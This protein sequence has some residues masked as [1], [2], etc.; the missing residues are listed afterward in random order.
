MI[1]PEDE[2]ENP[3]VLE[4]EYGTEG[5]KKRVQ[6]VRDGTPCYKY[7]RACHSSLVSEALSARIS[8]CIHVLVHVD[9][10]FVFSFFHRF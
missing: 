7:Q 3:C 8:D 1:I 2:S 5:I 4:C 9:Y 6:S 10:E